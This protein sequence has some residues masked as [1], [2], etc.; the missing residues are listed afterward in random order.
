MRR[1]S[2]QII[3][4]DHPYEPPQQPFVPAATDLPERRQAIGDV[5][6]A[7]V[8][9]LLPAVYNFLSFS[10]LPTDDRVTGS[11]M[12][13]LRV[14]NAVGLCILLASIWWFGLSILEL[15]TSLVNSLTG[16]RRKLPEWKQE[17]YKVLRR[18]P[19]LAWAGAVLW[20]VWT[21]AFY[22]LDVDFY[23]ISVPIGIAAHVLAAALYL[24]LFF[25]WY[26]LATEPRAR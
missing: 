3:L 17:L 9:L 22:Q 24:P 5:R 12:L 8:I 2:C 21:I 16:Q 4:S 11:L 15:I 7:L 26:R 14:L 23:L 19:Q 1:T 10:R 18:M 6:K 13:V 20:V 25:A